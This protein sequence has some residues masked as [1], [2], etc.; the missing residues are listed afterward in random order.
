MAL[1]P[2]QARGANPRLALT[3]APIISAAASNDVAGVRWALEREGTH[4]DAL[5]D[6]RG[7]RRGGPAGGPAG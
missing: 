3:T 7:A 1:Q 4:V 5:A 2:P 6:W